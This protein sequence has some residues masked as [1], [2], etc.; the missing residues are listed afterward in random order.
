MARARS[1]PLNPTVIVAVC[2]CI[3]ALEGYDIQAFGIAAP[4]MAAE[5]RLGPG[6]MG[7]AGSAAMVG[8]IFGAVIGGWVADRSGR[9]PVLAAAVAAFGAFSVATA[10]AHSFETLTLA[11]FLTGVGF[12]GA[13]PNLIAIATEISPP[14]RRAATTT[15]MFC[16]LPT[17]GALV[18]LLARSGGEALDWRTI[19]L[20]GGALP[21]LL[22]P[23]VL[24][25]IPETRPEPVQGADRRVSHGV[26]G[27]GR[28][29]ATL[30]IW[31]VFI[32]DLLV[33][34]L[35]INWLPTLVQAKGFTAADGASA[36]LWLNGFSVVGALILGRV[37][38]RV[39]F[40]WPATVVF[41]VLAG[42]MYGLAQAT[43]LPA[44]LGFAGA[45][46][47]TVV[48]GVYVLYA[49]APSFYPPQIRA[50]GAGAAIAVG[51]FGSIL[52]PVI[53]GQLRAG[54]Y[55]PGQVLEAMI[56]ASLAAAGAV[57]LL[58]TVGKPHE[59]GPAP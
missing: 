56:P 47:F 45:A 19:F 3:A 43:T 26:F 35:L 13:M 8:L 55:G 40:R 57:F 10:F 27:E 52:G 37:A 15:S 6:Q 33:T 21:I 17:G 24:A 11:R 54:G 18:A 39:G 1:G 59:D 32:L 36:A 38:D 31:L 42:A 12:G 30:L 34:Y 41:L 23:V 51:R 25:L 53:A 44:I 14:N 29:V 5:L 4:R 58:L 46:G 28:A 22:A 16:G 2:F 49:L 7:W 50:A 20:I 48:G 9:K